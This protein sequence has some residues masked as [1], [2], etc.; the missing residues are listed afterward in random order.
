MAIVTR[1]APSPTGYLHLGGARTALFNYVFA[2]SQGGQY[3]LRIEDTD[4]ARSTSDAIH[5]I[6]DGL[7]WLGLEGDAPAVMQSEQ[8]ARHREVAAALLESGHAY[9]CYL[10]DA[11]LETLRQKAKHDGVA[12]RSPWRDPAYDDASGEKNSDFVIR[13]RMPDEGMLTISDLVQGDVSVAAT[14]LDDMVICRSDGSP[15]YML[16]V[17]VDDHDMGITHVIRGDDHLNNAFR[18]MVI[19]QAMG[20]DIPAFAHI[21]LIHGQD[22]AKLSKR[23]GAVG[24]ESYREDGY[25]PEAMTNYLMRLG[26][27]HGDEELFTMAQ[28]IEWFDIAKV[29]KAPSRFDVDKLRSVN[30]HH[31][32]ESA[33]ETLAAFILEKADTP[34]SDEASSRLLALMPLLTERAMTLVEL[35]QGQDYLIYDGVP[36]MTEDAA[37]LLTD[38]AKGILVEFAESLPETLNTLDQLKDHLNAFLEARGL[39]MKHIGLPLRAALTGTKQSP[40]ITDIIVALGAKEVKRRIETICK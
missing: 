29:G 22:G 33:P 32:R 30:H 2:K 8:E 11:Q 14:Q 17:V 1:F 26:W 40:S 37:A 10:S 16:A 36:I 13:L 31:L 20:W 15:T 39:K 18:Q 35:C 12:L 3:L 23:H 34:I 21:P 6:H 25:L 27:S 7:S 28:A 9:R 4:K 19:Y 24:I 38:E 5:A